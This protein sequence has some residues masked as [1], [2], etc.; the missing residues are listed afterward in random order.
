MIPILSAVTWMYI[1]RL[2]E[3]CA[4]GTGVEIITLKGKGYLFSVVERGK[5]IVKSERFSFSVSV[6]VWLFVALW[7]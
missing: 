7:V 6:A 1:Y 2:R 4:L 5:L 3:Y